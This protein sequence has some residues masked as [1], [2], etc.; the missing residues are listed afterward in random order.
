[1]NVI[2]KYSTIVVLL[3]ASF[4]TTVVGLSSVNSVIFDEV[5]FG[6][7]ITAYCCTHERI[8]DIHPPHAK[9]LI[10]SVS[11]L[12]GYRGGFAFDHIGEDYGAVSPI[13]LRALPALAG[14]L[15]PLVLYAIL[16]VLNVSPLFSLLGGLLA[17]FDNALTVQ[18]RVIGLDTILLLAT[19]VSLWL[20]LVWL[21]R[22]H[23]RRLPGK[24]V[25]K[26]WLLVGSGAAAGL[27][28]GT[29]FTGLA[30]LGIIGCI[31]FI[32][33]LRNL[34][35]R[36]P[37]WPQRVQQIIVAGL[38]IVGTALV[39]YLVGWV[40]HFMVLTSPGSGDVWGVPTGNLVQ[41]TIQMHKKMFDANYNLTA[42]HPYSSFWW[43]WPAMVRPVFYWSG[44]NGAWIYFW[45][46]PVV[47]WGSAVF[48]VV[49]LSTYI[50][51]GVSRKRHPY[52]WIL[53]I[54]YGIT[55]LPFMRIPRALF[56][57]HYLTPLLFSLLFVMW[58]ADAYVPEKLR[59]TV[60]MSVAG[61]AL[62]G[63]ITF[64]PVT[65]GFDGWQSSLV[66]FS[67]WR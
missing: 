37:A 30:I 15:I 59:K 47:W 36:S 65:Y 25:Y 22:Y 40:V 44:T 4:A 20:F 51:D 63:F 53:I 62:A 17:A 27:A 45:G 61:L 18:S 38:T 34:W 2:R 42:E 64:L 58:W 43:T 10:A 49:A 48:F 1:M 6:K 35:K 26:T 7:F 50:A 57:Y 19:F 52:V 55:Y 14:A 66:W 54:A 29:K 67:S 11:Y 60:A 3:F 28:A 39:V 24:R 8:F 46:N 56:L 12:G 21:L 32:E 33:L 9:L 5:H 23:I 16:R 31:L 13:A 41:D